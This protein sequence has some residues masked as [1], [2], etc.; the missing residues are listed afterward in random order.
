MY[1]S[2][3]CHPTFK[4]LASLP[5]SVLSHFSHVWLFAD[6]WTVA[7]QTSLSMECSRQEYQSGLPF[8]PPGDLP[9]PGIETES[10]V[11]PALAG[12]FLIT[13]AT[14]ESPSF[15]CSTAK[16]ESLFS[17]PSP[18]V[19]CFRITS[20]LG[21][22]SELLKTQL[23]SPSLLSC[24][25]SSR[26]KTKLSQPG[27]KSGP[28]H[29]PSLLLHS[30]FL[31]DALQL[32]WP[33]HF[34]STTGPW[35]LLFLIWKDLSTT[36][37]PSHPPL[38]CCCSAAK[39]CPTLWD[40]MDCST[41]GF[42]V[43]HYFPEPAQIHIHWVSDAIQPSHPLSSLLFLP[44]IFPSIR[45]FSNVSALSHQVAKMLVL[46]LQHWSSHLSFPLQLKL[47]FLGKT[48]LTSSPTLLESSF[49]VTNSSSVL[50]D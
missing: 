3:L 9:D 1:F 12:G 7:C 36:P 13:G 50:P 34:S 40:L 14:R 29:F 25:F 38:V 22:H 35:H 33:C 44:S 46:Q 20:L 10:L 28:N 47:T 11:S 27:Y 18:L 45:V 37:S 43:L 5:V 8:P 19:S 6:L 2:N 4:Q 32:Y 49:I 39:L 21:S 15:A 42:P 17:S 30:L 23:W 41:P 16:N 31:S 48:S 26:T 24:L